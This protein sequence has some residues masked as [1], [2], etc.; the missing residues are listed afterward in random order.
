MSSNDQT[1]S[2]VSGL[3]I[4]NGFHPVS[5][6]IEAILRD[7]GFWYQRFEHEPVRTSEEAAKMRPE[8][9]QHQGTK[10]LIVNARP[11]GESGS[12]EKRFIMVVV[13]GDMQFDKKKVRAAINFDDLR[14]ANEEEVGRITKGVLP[15]GVPPFGH[16]FGLTVFMD[17]KIFENEKV[18]FN[19]GDRRISIGMKSAD[20][21]TIVNPIVA[22]IAVLKQS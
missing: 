8:Y 15:G 6:Q 10:S 19:A 1:T 16:L 12:R 7:G 11:L 5:E 22:D 4:S 2:E 9:V 18:I 21:R 20:L 14:F 17:E 13:P 3:P